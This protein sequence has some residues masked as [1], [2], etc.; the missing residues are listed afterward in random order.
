MEYETPGGGEDRG[1]DAK[2]KMGISDLERPKCLLCGCA[3]AGG[4][5]VA[6]RTFQQQ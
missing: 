4:V 6:D 2:V 1:H 5:L 3:F